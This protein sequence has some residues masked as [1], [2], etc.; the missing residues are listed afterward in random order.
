MGHLGVTEWENLGYRDSGMKG[1]PG[2][3]D[4]R[5]FWQ[6]PLDDAVR[7]LAWLVRVYRPDVITTYNDFGGYG[8]PDHVRAHQVAV[9]AFDRSGNPAWYPEQIAPEH[10]GTGPETTQGGLAPW[11]PAKL[12]EQA[13]PRTLREVLTA[14][15]EAAGIHSFWSR[16]VDGSPDE[17]AAWEE[18]TGRSTVPDEAVTTRVDVAVFATARFAALR[19]HRTQIAPDSPQVALGPDA[20]AEL[21][22]S[23]SF[24]LRA[25]RI[26]V[27]LPETDLFAGLR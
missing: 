25:A 4:P 3:R 8:H 23:E 14:R 22:G 10:G 20:W 13:W 26:P 2:N 7:R 27:T 17:L 21:V 19:A 15:L 12:Y 18:F 24:V 1:D 11:A 5:A 16:P 9:A 6:A